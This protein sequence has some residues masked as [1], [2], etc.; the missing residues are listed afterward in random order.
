M[1]GGGTRRYAPT[2]SAA[3]GRGVSV[4]APGGQPGIAP[5]SPP[6]PPAE[7]RAGPLSDRPRWRWREPG[8]G[9]GQT[10]RGKGGGGAR[11]G[12]EGGETTPR[13]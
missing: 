2:L 9:S 10:P 5:K 3:G 6:P 1:W 8:P 7:A 11:P 13:G 12:G 4:A